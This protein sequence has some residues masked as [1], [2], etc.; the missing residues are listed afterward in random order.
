MTDILKDEV[1]YNGLNKAIQY[2]IAR[3]PITHGAYLSPARKINLFEN[4]N[5]YL[6]C[7]CYSLF[8]V[9]DETIQKPHLRGTYT[10]KID[11]SNKRVK[12]ALNLFD[13]ALSLRTQYTDWDQK[14]PN[15]ELFD[16]ENTY[17]IERTNGLFVSAMTFILSHEVAHNYFNHITYNPPV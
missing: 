6:W 8:V 13:Y 3:A 11:P 14:L 12:E 2:N 17:Y 9:F 15:P 1:T 4:F 16:C 10:G 5:A 7:I